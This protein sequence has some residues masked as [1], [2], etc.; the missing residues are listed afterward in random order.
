MS[1]TL[2]AQFA[3]LGIM[4]VLAGIAVHLMWLFIKR[5][6]GRDDGDYP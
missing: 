5:T 4:T 3:S 6:E 1:E 2:V